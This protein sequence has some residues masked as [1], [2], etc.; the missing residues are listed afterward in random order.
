[1]KHSTIR[2]LFIIST[3]LLINMGCEKNSGETEDSFLESFDSL[4]INRKTV[5]AGETATIKAYATGTNIQFSWETS[6]G[7]ILPSADSAT[8]LPHACSAGNQTITCTAQGTNKEKQKSV[9]I[10]VE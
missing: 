3:V 10:M 1:M 5:P 8:Y 6:A 7:D 4:T 9:T 2:F